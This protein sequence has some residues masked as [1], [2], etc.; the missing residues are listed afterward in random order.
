[1]ALNRALLFRRATRHP[2]RAATV[3]IVVI[4]VNGQAK[5]SAGGQVTPLLAGPPLLS[6]NLA[7]AKVGRRHPDGGP[8]LHTI[9]QGVGVLH[10]WKR[11]KHR[12]C[13]DSASGLVGKPFPLVRSCREDA[14][15]RER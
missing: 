3:R 5:L 12:G 4:D 2:Y 9:Q 11:G 1:M 14:V 10:L 7:G 6:A 15:A 8:I 13:R